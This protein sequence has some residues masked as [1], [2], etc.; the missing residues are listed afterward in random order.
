MCRRGDVHFDAVL[1]KRHTVAARRGRL[2]WL[3][4]IA[5]TVTVVFTCE[6]HYRN[7]AKIWTARPV[8]MCLRKSNDRSVAMLIS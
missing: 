8:Q 2:G 3:V 7:V 5:P 4:E 6:R 1:L